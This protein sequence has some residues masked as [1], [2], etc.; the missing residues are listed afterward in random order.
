MNKTIWFIVVTFNPDIKKLLSLLS[1][2]KNWNVILIDNSPHLPNYPNFPNNIRLIKN[3]RNLGFGPAFNIA[4]LVALKNS[5]R[6]IINI[7]P[8][9]EITTKALSFFNR[10][11]INK[12]ADIYGSFAGWFDKKR[13]TTILPE[14]QNETVIKYD[15]LSGEFLAIYNEVFI[16][17][18]FFYEPYFLYYEDADFC[19]RAKKN[20]FKLKYLYHAGIKHESTTTLGRNSFL[21][22]YYLARN[23]L[24]FVERN[25]PMSVKIYELIRFP[26]T[27]WQHL[28]QK[29]P[30]ALFGIKDYLLRRFGKIMD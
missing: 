26:K 22:Q 10:H 16:K 3:Q 20:G 21:H 11:L 4:A 27:I 30:G 23:H 8:D 9:I 14:K 12:K 29:Q 24:L 5:A 15:Y 13:C 2:L 19:A 7:S 28:R 17:I 1:K 25:A 18:G 6:W